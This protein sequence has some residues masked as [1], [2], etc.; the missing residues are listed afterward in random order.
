MPAAS[1]MPYSV[2]EQFVEAFVDH[3]RRLVIGD[4]FAEGVQVGP[5]ISSGQRQSVEAYIELAR[6]A[7][8]RVLCGGGRPQSPGFYLEPTIIDGLPSGARVCQEE[9]FGP[10]AVVIPFRD[11]QE[12]LTLANDT[13]FGLSGS[14]WT[15]DIERALRVARRVDSGVLSVNTNSSVYQEAPF[16]GFKRSGFGRDLGMEALRL[17]TE[18]KN[19]YIKISEAPGA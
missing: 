3:T 17:Y 16:G 4:P 2:Y 7:G 1:N 15:R 8:G 9:I 6:Q 5:M 13:P 12:A 14:I 18:V 10:V 19:V 11:E